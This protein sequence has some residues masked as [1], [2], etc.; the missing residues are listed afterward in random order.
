MPPPPPTVMVITSF[1][2]AHLCG[3]LVVTIPAF[4]TPGLTAVIV[5]NWFAPIGGVFIPN[6][7]IFATLSSDELVTL[8]IIVQSLKGLITVKLAVPGTPGM[9]IAGGM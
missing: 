3:T 4:V 6:G 2:N 5:N 1:P 8:K 7:A 9:F